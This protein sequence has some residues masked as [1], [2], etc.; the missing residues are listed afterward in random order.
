MGADPRSGGPTRQPNLEGPGAPNGQPRKGKR[1]GPGGSGGPRLSPCTLSGTYTLDGGTD[2]TEGQSYTS[3]SNDVS[4]VYVKNGGV[5]RLVNPQITTMGNTSSQENSSFYGLNAGVLAGKGSK[6]AISGGSIITSGKG[7]NGAF[8]AVPA[9]KS[10]SPTSPSRQPP[11][12][13]MV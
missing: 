5:L 4:A 3:A 11:L 9:Q 8:A 7:A 13:A 10:R 2:S 1:G 6:I 12:A